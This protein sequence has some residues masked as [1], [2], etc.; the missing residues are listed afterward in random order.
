M[1]RLS[2][3]DINED[4]FILYSLT[5]IYGIGLSRAK[6]ICN[7]CNINYYK[8]IKDL[9]NNEINIVRNKISKFMV[10]GDLRRE[11]ML[12]IKRLIDINS[13]RGL[14]HKKKLPVRGQ[15]TKTNAKTCKKIRKFKK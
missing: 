4:K 13:Y 14:R 11:V 7:L 8:K 5:S 6:L 15:R 3:V 12:N 1:I 2:G 10:E 9:N